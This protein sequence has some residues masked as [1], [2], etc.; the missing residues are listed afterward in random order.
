[1]K[2]RLLLRKGMGWAIIVCFA[3]IALNEFYVRDLIM[4]WFPQFSA[5][6]EHFIGFVLP[7]ALFVVFLPIFW[8]TRPLKERAKRI[9]VKKLVVEAK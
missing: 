5:Q 2:F 6:Y 4:A 3:I 8:F 1:M 7:I 9:K